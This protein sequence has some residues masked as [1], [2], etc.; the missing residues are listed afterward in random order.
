MVMIESEEAPLSWKVGQLL[1]DHDSHEQR[2]NYVR[3]RSGMQN[4][5]E[6]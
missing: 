5:V 6:H 2:A 4:P 3:W 1:S